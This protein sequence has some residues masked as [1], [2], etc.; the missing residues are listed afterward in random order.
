[1]MM[2]NKVKTKINKNKINDETSYTLVVSALI[3]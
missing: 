1:M 3:V 2:I